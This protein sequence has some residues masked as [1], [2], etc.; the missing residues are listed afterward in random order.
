VPGFSI[1]FKGVWESYCGW[2]EGNGES[3]LGRK[4]WVQA[5]ETHGHAVI[6]KSGRTTVQGLRVK[7]DDTAPRQGRW[8]ERD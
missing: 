4:R 6:T 2:C 8:G 1:P 7:V 3:P 5:M